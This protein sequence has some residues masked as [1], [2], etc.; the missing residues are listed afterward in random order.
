MK[1]YISMKTQ[2]FDEFVNR[3][4]SLLFSFK[5]SLKSQKRNMSFSCTI[6]RKIFFSKCIYFVWSNNFDQLCLKLRTFWSSTQNSI[7]CKEI[8]SKTKLWFS[9]W[10]TST[11][12]CRTVSWV[13]IVQIFS[14]SIVIFCCLFVHWKFNLFTYTECNSVFI[15]SYIHTECNSVCPSAQKGRCHWSL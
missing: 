2:S 15:H 3:S 5:I 10:N 11:M 14:V 9:A 7:L 6:S 12:D 8:S 4:E 1:K 13:V